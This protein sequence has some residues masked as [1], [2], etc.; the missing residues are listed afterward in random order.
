MLRD[1]HPSATGM[2]VFDTAL[3]P[4]AFAWGDLGVVGVQLPEGD[5]AHTLRRLGR[6]FPDATV[7]AV[8][9][10]LR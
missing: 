5:A 6:R 8:P 2:A 1:P 3:G 4:C 9:P 7:Q 10:T